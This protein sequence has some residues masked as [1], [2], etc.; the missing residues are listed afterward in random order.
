M[1]AKCLFSDQVD[2]D[3]ISEYIESLQTEKNQGRN[4]IV[5][6]NG[7]ED[8]L[9]IQLKRKIILINKELFTNYLINFRLI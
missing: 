4:F 1:V 6:F 7:L 3:T 2:L 8:K 9:P 5:H